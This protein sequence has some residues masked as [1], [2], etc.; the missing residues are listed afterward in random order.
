VTD[1]ASPAPAKKKFTPLQKRIRREA[2]QKAAAAGLDWEAM[3][4]DD[5]QKM[6]QEVRQALKAEREEKEARRVKTES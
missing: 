2:I 6:R 4:K 3:P 5:R 1:A